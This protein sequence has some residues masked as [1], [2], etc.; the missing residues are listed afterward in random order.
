MTL[1]KVE[2][3]QAELERLEERLDEIKSAA[4]MLGQNIR[5]LR[6]FFEDLIEDIRE[7]E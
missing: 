5:D 1:E 2:Q 4:T 7:A 6:Y 3:A